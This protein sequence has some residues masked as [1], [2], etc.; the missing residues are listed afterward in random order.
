MISVKNVHCVF[1]SGTVLEN[2]ALR[3][4]SLDIDEGEFLTVI[5]SNGAGKS[6]LLNVLSGEAPVTSGSVSI[7][8]NDVTRWA[9]HKRANL[10]ARVFQDPLVGTCEAL[11]IEENMALAAKR[12]QKRGMRLASSAAMRVQFKAELS[13]LGLGV[14][15]RLGELMGLLSGGQR[16]SV[17]LIMAS[18]AGSDILLLDEHTSALDPASADFV[19]GLTDRIVREKR[20]TTLMVTHSMRLA[21]S[22]G[23][24]TIMLDG[25]KIILDIKGE[26]RKSAT[27]DDLL[28]LFSKN[29]GKAIDH[30]ALLLA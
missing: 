22:H 26:E 25:G 24:R 11:S 10:T 13:R 14:E 16:Q 1:N 5:G 15:S 30:D 12:G 9:T 27:V 8:G 3:G 20:L 19:L 7:A 28:T 18:L 17:S 21:L 23:T 6:T 4:I 29:R 2:R